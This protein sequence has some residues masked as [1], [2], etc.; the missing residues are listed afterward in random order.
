M[1]KD[2]KSMFGFYCKTPLFHWC[3]NN[4]LKEEAFN[5]VKIDELFTDKLRNQLYDEYYSKLDFFVNSMGLYGKDS[6]ADS[7]QMS[8]R[9]TAPEFV[10]FYKTALDVF[11]EKDYVSKDPIN[12]SIVVKSFLAQLDRSFLKVYTMFML[13]TLTTTKTSEDGIN[14][15]EQRYSDMISMM[16]AK[17]DTSELS[18]S[19]KTQPFFTMEPGYLFGSYSFIESM[20]NPELLNNI[21]EADTSY[22]SVEIQWKYT[23]SGIDELKLMPIFWKSFFDVMLNVVDHSFIICGY[24]PSTLYDDLSEYAMTVTAESYP[25]DFVNLITYFLNVN[26]TGHPLLLLHQYNHEHEAFKKEEEENQEEI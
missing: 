19:S 24:H 8:K 16:Q 1:S 21:S 11:K 6:I 23:L 7:V 3:E 9:I 22:Y 26:S 5:K 4:I 15:I 13:S 14:R 20:V 12:D 18:E 2:V 17:I 25:K 10:D